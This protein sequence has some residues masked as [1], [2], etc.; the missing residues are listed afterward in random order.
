MINPEAIW[1]D[2]LADQLRRA[3][4]GLA[5]FVGELDHLNQQARVW[6]TRVRHGDRFFYEGRTAATHARQCRQKI[7]GAEVQVVFFTALIAK[8]QEMTPP[9]SETCGA[10]AG[11]DQC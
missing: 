7:A 1:R 11:M 2:M 3:R 10:A 6:E 8:L 5:E 4:A 9:T